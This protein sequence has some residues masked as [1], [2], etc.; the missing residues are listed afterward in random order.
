LRRSKRGPLSAI[1][2]LVLPGRIDPVSLELI[3]KLRL[4]YFYFFT[5]VKSKGLLFQ[6]VHPKQKDSYSL[7]LP[8]IEIQSVSNEY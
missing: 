6:L 5:H 7:I 4:L 8:L 3:S 2:N 1:G